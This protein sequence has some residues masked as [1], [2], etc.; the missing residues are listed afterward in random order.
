MFDSRNN[1]KDPW[2]D[3]DRQRSLRSILNQPETMADLVFIAFNSQVIALNRI[4]GTTVWDWKA[5]RGRSSMVAVLLDGDQLIASVQGYTYALNVL[6]GEVLWEN[7]LKGKG[8]GL[9]TIT[10]VRGSSASPAAAA[11][12]IAQQQAA[13]AGAG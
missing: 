10:S 6:T 12:V 3:I 11:A 9:P 1:T 13:A 8:Y 2:A 4:D 5:P 7:Q